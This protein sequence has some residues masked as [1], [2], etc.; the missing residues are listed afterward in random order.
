MAKQTLE[1]WLKNVAN[2]DEKVI[3]TTIESFNKEEIFEV[4]DVLGLKDSDLSDIGLKLGT[5]KKITEA[6]ASEANKKKES[7]SSPPVETKNLEQDLPNNSQGNELPKIE[8]LTVNSSEGESDSVS[9]SS[10]VE[11]SVANHANLLAKNENNSSK[12]SNVSSSS[13]SVLPPDVRYSYNTQDSSNMSEDSSPPVTSGSSHSHSYSDTGSTPSVL[14]AKDAKNLYIIGVFYDDFNQAVR[15]YES[16]LEKKKNEPDKKTKESFLKVLGSALENSDEIRTVSAFPTVNSAECGDNTIV[17]V[18]VPSGKMITFGST[19]ISPIVLGSAQPLPSSNHQFLAGDFD[20]YDHVSCGPFHS[21]ALCSNNRIHSWGYNINCSIIGINGEENKKRLQIDHNYEIAGQLGRG[22]GFFKEPGVVKISLPTGVTIKKV[23]AGG[24]HSALITS[25]GGLYMW[26]LN[27]EGQLGMENQMVKNAKTGKSKIR[28][29][30][31]KPTL[32]A[33]LKGHI[34]TSVACGGHH[35]LALTSTGKVFGFGFN[36]LG[37]LGIGGNLPTSSTNLS[38]FCVYNPTEIPFTKPIKS[39]AAGT[40]HSIAL[41]DDYSVYTWGDNVFGEL[42]RKKGKQNEP[43]EVT[44]PTNG[45]LDGSIPIIVKIS[46][47]AGTSAA[48]SDN[49]RAF[50][51]GRLAGDKMTCHQM[52][53]RLLNSKV[54]QRLFVMDV[55]CGSAHF[56]ISA[57]EYFTSSLNFL[58]SVMADENRYVDNEIRER[59]ED[60]PDEMFGTIQDRAIQRYLEKNGDAPCLQCD[61][62]SALFK[63]DKDTSSLHLEIEIQNTSNNQCNVRSCILASLNHTI[64]INP[65]QF[66]LKPKKGGIV[67]LTLNCAPNSIA[68]HISQVIC[69]VAESPG[70]SKAVGKF[71][72]SYRITPTY[73]PANVLKLSLGMS[74]R[75]SSSNASSPVSERN[76]RSV[77]HR[78][79]GHSSSSSYVYDFNSVELFEKLGTGG[80]GASVYRCSLE[81]FSCAVKILNLKDA[82]EE[83]RSSFIDEVSIIETLQHDNIVRYLGHD[84]VDHKVRLFMEYYPY[85]LHAVIQKRRGTPFS[86]KEIIKCCLSVAKGLAYLHNF[87]HPIVHRDLKSGNVLVALD[88]SDSIKLIKITDFDTSKVLTD[89]MK[90]STIA[91]TPAFIAPEIYSKSK[92]GYTVQADIW[93]FGMLIIELLTLKTPY[94]QYAQM[95]IPDLIMKGIQPKIPPITDPAIAPIINIMNRCLNMEPT[96]RPNSRALVSELAFL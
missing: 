7:S 13:A 96:Q 67:K 92:V 1:D 62:N 81:G 34:I 41:S 60:I 19:E 86:S 66:V 32:V 51:W 49:G 83:E 59:I 40:T 31:K 50:I 15:S 9:S 4:N 94:H 36:N 61:T 18:E 35:T 74:K 25:D 46:A 77:A 45:S 33:S 88:E 20:R 12:N 29:T 69:F 16:H 90:T 71:Y 80:S 75:S 11:Q 76:P 64:D 44:F 3:G 54:A 68:E 85:S 27:H 22:K 23:N 6:I 73:I 89:G 17:A 5:R 57:S 42:G 63:L 56:C 91:G 26:G 72:F 65:S 8:V 2:L 38:S 47:G 30:V 53:P 28:T 93:S 87:Q 52:I 48:V 39:I 95:E 37:Q 84:I 24:V 78:Q 14:S 43:G 55:A 79:V 21:L 58:T 70:K 10:R 82:S